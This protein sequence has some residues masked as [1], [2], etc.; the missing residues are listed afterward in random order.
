MFIQMYISL[1]F[2]YMLFLTLRYFQSPH[3]TLPTELKPKNLKSGAF[4]I[5]IFCIFFSNALLFYQLTLAEAQVS[6]S[7][8]IL[9]GVCLSVCNLHIIKILSRLT[10]QFQQLIIKHP[11]AKGIPNC[12]NKE[13]RFF[14]RGDII[15]N[16]RNVHKSPLNHLARQS[17]FAF[18]VP[19]AFIVPE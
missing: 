5:S 7:D 10:G 12:E 4:K 19:S 6:L 13:S 1:I 17:T 15:R 8:D 2:V 3:F 14:L 11:Y 9:S 18:P 16:Y